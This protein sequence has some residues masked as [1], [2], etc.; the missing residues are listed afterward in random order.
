MT[1]RRRCA[2]S[3][4]LPERTET[5]GEARCD[6]CGRTFHLLTSGQLPRHYDT[7][8]WVPDAEGGSYH[9][10]DTSRTV[11]TMPMP[12]DDR[13]PGD[14]APE[15]RWKKAIDRVLNSGLMFPHMGE[16]WAY[17]DGEITWDEF[18]DRM[19]P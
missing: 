13:A 4:T 2:G 18:D 12:G 16:F 15:E 3:N 7:R 5:A 8:V 19:S 10:S 1:T 9:H 17:V 11:A 14:S 6:T